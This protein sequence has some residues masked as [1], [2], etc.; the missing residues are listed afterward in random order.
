M[1]CVV[2]APT[3]GGKTLIAEVATAQLLDDNP[4]AKAMYVLP[5]VALAAEK[6]HDFERRFPRYCVRPFFENMGK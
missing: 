5:F 3:S 6:A 4:L 2:V 1:S